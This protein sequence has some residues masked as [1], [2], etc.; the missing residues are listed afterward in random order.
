MVLRSITGRTMVSYQF[1]RSGTPESVIQN[2][3]FTTIL[4]P[5]SHRQHIYLLASGTCTHWAKLTTFPF[6]L[7]GS[8]LIDR[9]SSG[10]T[11]ET[12]WSRLIFY[13]SP[14]VILLL[15]RKPLC[16]LEQYCKSQ[17]IIIHKVVLQFHNSASTNTS[18]VMKLV[19]GMRYEQNM[20]ERSKNS[21]NVEM[22]IFM[23]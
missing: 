17:I 12:T 8:V 19:Y 20:G 3:A 21:N 6:F 16:N 7:S 10:Q 9:R 11:C 18:I 1:S 13:I 23:K 22:R 4:H 5:I 2:I 15:F 14:I